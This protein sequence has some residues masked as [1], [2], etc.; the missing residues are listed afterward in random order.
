M[1]SVTNIYYQCLT[2]AVTYKVCKSSLRSIFDNGKV[3]LQDDI[4]GETIIPM[5]DE[6]NKEIETRAEFISV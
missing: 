2:S 4:E 5:V 6:N 3:G 1:R